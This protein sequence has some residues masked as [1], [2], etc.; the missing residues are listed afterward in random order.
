M[1]PA[2][3]SDAGDNLT[4]S[5]T[6]AAAGGGGGGGSDVLDWTASLGFG[7]LSSPEDHQQY[8]QQQHQDDGANATAA[9]AAAA[10]S[11]LGTVSTAGNGGGDG[12]GGG[13]GGGCLGA[14]CLPAG[15]HPASGLTRDT[16]I[17]ASGCGVG[18]AEKVSR[19][20]EDGEDG[21]NDGNRD[22]FERREALVPL[23]SDVIASGGR[24]NDNN[25]HSDFEMGEA[26]GALFGDVSESGRSARVAMRVDEADDDAVAVRLPVRE[27]VDWGASL[28]V[29][30]SVLKEEQEEVVMVEER[31]EDGGVEEEDGELDEVEIVGEEEHVV[32][33]VEEGKE[34]DGMAEEE[35][36]EEE[37][38]EELDE[39]A[40]VGEEERIEVAEEELEE[41]DVVEM[42]EVRGG[43]ELNAVGVI[44][45]ER[46]EEGQAA[47][48]VDPSSTPSAPAA[49]WFNRIRSTI[50]ATT[51]SSRA[52]GLL[53]WARRT[54]SVA[55]AP[56]VG[57][58]EGVSS[59]DSTRALPDNFTIAA[60]R[61]EG[62][63]ESQELVGAKSVGGGWR[64]YPGA[65]PYRKDAGIAEEWGMRQAWETFRLV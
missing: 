63:Q 51:V 57:S 26:L 28:N 4:P 65:I 61:P 59:T 19:N 6:A 29:L 11:S 58:G 47:A 36:K 44:G 10:T 18:A 20:S 50:S 3:R 1:K 54:S 27:E 39:V 45:E 46:E 35:E 49:P 16:D 17:D 23:L 55:G 62:S 2:L 41:L 9:A 33:V 52:Q 56:L 43:R 31:E 53:R 21:Y 15:T 30:F 22:D 40:L 24:V 42:M 34:E 48:P 60:K 32:V 25:D 64:N 13:G 37:E 8:Q 12:G 5:T 38:D 14:S 7:F